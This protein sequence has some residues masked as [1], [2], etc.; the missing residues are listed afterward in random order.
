[1][2]RRL[3]ADPDQ[4]LPLRV[5]NVIGAS[6]GSCSGFLILAA[7]MDVFPPSSSSP[8]A[9]TTTPTTAAL[10][11]YHAK[12]RHVL[13]VA[14]VLY[15]RGQS[16][17]LG[18][19]LNGACQ[20][21][22]Q[23]GFWERLY[24]YLLCHMQGHEH[25]W[26]AVRGRLHLAVRDNLWRDQAGVWRCPHRNYVLHDFDNREQLVAALVATGEASL[27]G[28]I[29]GID[30]A[31]PRFRPLPDHGGEPERPTGQCELP[32]SYWDGGEA[33]LTIPPPPGTAADA[34]PLLFFGTA[35]FSG[36]HFRRT[37]VA[38]LRLEDVVPLLEWGVR[39]TLGALASP[40]L[41]F[42]AS[43]PANTST[44]FGD[45]FAVM[46][47]TG[48]ADDEHGGGGGR[49]SATALVVGGERLAVPEGVKARFEAT[50]FQYPGQKATFCAIRSKVLR[51][52]QYCQIIS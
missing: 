10:A 2:L 23:T 20:S 5:G 21:V 38:L 33:V 19:W 26:A 46:A 31:L 13:V 47:D 25:L 37:A 8:A 40:N 15:A 22:R 7:T 36:V 11:A 9:P 34:R 41:A 6:G 32:R 29:R 14:Y 39:T 12:M 17:G 27:R 42:P 3:P 51:A 49:R 1:M 30:I 48:S 18:V 52:V 45:L 35:D 4:P 24:A 50:A 16:A 44:P 28:A 43:A